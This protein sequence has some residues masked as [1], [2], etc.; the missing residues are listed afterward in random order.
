[1]GL[2]AAKMAVGLGANVTI[3]D[4]NAKRL[5]YLDDIFGGRVQTLLSNP[6]NIADRKNSSQAMSNLAG[7]FGKSTIRIMGGKSK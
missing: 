7:F 4:L 6:F 5:A 3:I 2:N 1:M